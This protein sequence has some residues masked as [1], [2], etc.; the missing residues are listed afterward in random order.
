MSDVEASKTGVLKMG[1]AD[2]ALQSTPL[3]VIYFDSAPSLSHLNGII[4]VTLVVTCN[5]P[6]SDKGV[7]SV[8]SVAAHLKCNIPAAVALRNALN[9]ALLLAAP[10]EKPE[11]AKN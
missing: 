8:A 9:D 7:I 10:V 1:D 5:V 6:D 11:G 2:V 4:G 3:P